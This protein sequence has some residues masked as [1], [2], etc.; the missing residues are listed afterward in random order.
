[1]KMQDTIRRA[2]RSLRQA[3]A[4]TLLTSLAIGV[5]AF[6]ITLALAAGEGGRAYTDAIVQA[7]TD[8][9]E[10]TVTK[11][12]AKTQTGPQEYSESASAA[13]ANPAAQ[14]FGG[15]DVLLQSDID[16]IK[17]VE[18]V[19]SVAPNYNPQVK[20]VTYN[21]TDKYIAMV[22]TGSSSVQLKYAA[23][24]IQGELSN[25][26]IV[27]TEEYATALGFSSPQAA[28]GQTVRVV[29][30]KQA[31]PVLAPE[32]KTFAYTVKAVSSKSGLAFRAQS[33]L[34]VS[35][36]SAKLLYDYINKGTRAYGSYA[37]AAVQ[38]DDPINA[39]LTKTT[40]AKMGYTA[41]TAKDV[42]GT[43][44]TFI[45]VLQGILLGFGALAVLTSIFGI[46]NTQYISVL[47]RTQQI[48][49]MKALGMRQRDV[50]R[51]FRYEAAWVGFLGGVIGSGMAVIAGLIAN[52]FIRDALNLGDINLLIF[53]SSAVLAVIAGLMLVSVA[54]GM[55]P[56]RKAAKLDPIEALRT[57]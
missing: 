39:E 45:N 21:G 12:P 26:D 9:K 44:N 15:T 56:A 28:I 41:Q 7:N 17:R 37:V 25:D 13:A 1:M 11:T 18:H 20:Y 40:L 30:D 46:I 38:I 8:V 27:L 50:G 2:G 10:L 4:R 47:E 36:A 16:K 6:T 22:S 29:A 55:L 43:I 19:S 49:L 24:G 35:N 31:S 34:L 48:G 5:G 53:N 42:L 57:E 33:S 54:A 32:S 52:P 51:L 14:L 23:G 3:K